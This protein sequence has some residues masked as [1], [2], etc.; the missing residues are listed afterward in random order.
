MGAAESDW[1]L[2]LD[3]ANREL[4]T[5]K[6]EKS[7]LAEK[8]PSSTEPEMQ[9]Q[10]TELQLKLAKEEEEKISVTKLNQDLKQEVE[11]ISKE[12]VSE[13]SRLEVVDRDF[14]EM[15]TTNI[16]LKQL[17]H[18]TQ[19]AL[20]K[21]Q[22]LVKSFQ[23]QLQDNKVDESLITSGPKSNTSMGSTRSNI[24]RKSMTMQGQFYGAKLSNS[25]RK[26]FNW[27]DF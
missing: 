6:L 15:E 4:I 16:S 3:I 22:N 8:P 9:E 20:S 2:K 26:S 13:R 11:R 1:K 18:S 12:L 25:V 27:E 24:S 14:K 17:V 23:E 10:L 5:L 21:E 7:K 19:E